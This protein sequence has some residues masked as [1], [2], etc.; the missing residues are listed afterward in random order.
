MSPTLN[1][2]EQLAR[3]AGEIL[4]AG[5]NPIPGQGNHLHIDHKGVIDLVTEIDHRS[6]A[7]IIE[8]IQTSFP[9]DR[10]IAEESGTSPGD[11]WRIWYIDPLD[12]TINFAHGVPFFAVS[13]AYQQEGQVQLGV[14]YDPLRNEC[15]T[16]ERGRGAWLNGKVLRV[17]Q[18]SQLNDS[19]LVTGFPYDIRTTSQNNLENYAHLI[20][21]SQSV[22]RLGAA[23]LDVCYV[24]AGRFDGFWEMDI[25]PWDVAAGGLV[26]EE[27]GALVTNASGGAE[28]LSPPNS[29]LAANPAIHA[30]ILAI[31][32]D[33]A[34]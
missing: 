24:A 25:S 18:T 8:Q 29:I 17:S 3:Q 19:L 21:K 22:S 23:A 28:Y 26:A 31:L 11:D 4:H 12:G 1:Y 30:Q 33:S 10:I 16:A 13:I 32:N 9:G 2:I 7:F 27:A 20:L 5:Y 15:F 14:V 6:E 34:S